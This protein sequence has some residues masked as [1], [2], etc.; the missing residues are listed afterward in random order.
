MLNDTNVRPFTRNYDHS[1]NSIISILLFFRVIVEL[2]AVQYVALDHF[3][4]LI[5]LF[6]HFRVVDDDFHVVGINDQAVQVGWV[7]FDEFLVEFAGL[8]DLGC[9]EFSIGD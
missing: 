2:G 6:I 3:Y 1:C 9:D 4:D 5:A 8:F 7:D